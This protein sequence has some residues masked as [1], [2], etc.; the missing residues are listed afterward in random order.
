MTSNIKDEGK[1]R[2]VVLLTDAEYIM[3]IGSGHMLPLIFEETKKQGYPLDY[4]FIKPMEWYPVRLRYV[5]LMSIT[6]VLHFD[7]N[8]LRDMGS[9]ASRHSFITRLMLRY[10]VNMDSVAKNIQKYWNKNYSMGIIKAVDKKGTFYICIKDC[11]VPHQVFPY[12]EGYFNSIVELVVG[13]G[14]NISMKEFRWKHITGDCLEFAIN[15]K[16]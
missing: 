6:K 8:Q 9:K 2:G 4:A 13:K 12:M 10:L 7:D 3:N 15:Y 16:K 5:S 1:V 11:P 14:K